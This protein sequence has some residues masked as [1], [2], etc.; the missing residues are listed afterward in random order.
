MGRQDCEKTDDGWMDGFQQTDNK[1]MD[2]KMD[3]QSVDFFHREVCG[4]FCRRL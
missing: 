1:G 4:N 3:V 2:R